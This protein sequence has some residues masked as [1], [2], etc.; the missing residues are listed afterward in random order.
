M[1]EV[2]DAAYEDYQKLRNS[3]TALIGQQGRL[4]RALLAETEL[5]AD[6]ENGIC[7]LFRN[8]FNYNAAVSSKRDQELRGIL[9]EKY[10]TDFRISLKLLKES[11]QAP[12]IVRGK[13]IPGIE[14]DI[15]E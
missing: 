2:T 10:G 11:E 8:E 13:R 12:E 5:S 15:E 6:G 7:I 1:I 4:F 14:M 9:R 3:W